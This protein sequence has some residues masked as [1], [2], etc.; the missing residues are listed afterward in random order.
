M[1]NRFFHP[2][3]VVSAVS[4][5]NALLTIIIALILHQQA[6]QWHAM[7]LDG[8]AGAILLV[9]GV[10]WVLAFITRRNVA[11]VRLIAVSHLAGAIATPLIV[12]DYWT[13][14]IFMLVLIPLEMAIADRVRNIPP[15]IIASLLGSA[16]M[17]AIDLLIPLNYPRESLTAFPW[18]ATTML[19]V[20]SLHLVALVFLLWY[21]RLR[22]RAPFPIRIDLGTQQSLIF[23]AISAFGIVIVTGVLIHQIHK[24]QLNQVGQN[25]QTLSQIN[26]ERVRNNLEQQI[27]VLNDLWRREQVLLDGLKSANASYPQDPEEVRQ[28]LVERE[29]L[30][31]TSPENSPFILNYRTNP[32]THVLNEFRGNNLLHTNLLLIDQHGGLVAAQGEKPDHFSFEHTD[33]WQ[34]TWNYGLGGTYL[35]H[36]AI[37]Q[38]TNLATILIAV[39]IIDPKTNQLMGVL[40]STYQL[41]SI[42]AMVTTAESSIDGEMFL[43]HASGITIASTQE[44]LIGHVPWP[45]LFISGTL[46]ARSESR[47]MYGQDYR[48]QESIIAYASLNRQSGEVVDP[49]GEL[50]WHIVVS[51]TRE[52]ALSQVIRSSKIAALVGLIVMALGIIVVNI[53][54]RIITR[55]IDALT[56]TAAIITEGNLDQR[57][58]PVGPVELV[59]LA[60]AFNTQTDRLRSLINN[61]QDQVAERTLQLEQRVRQLQDL[62]TRLQGELELARDIQQSLLPPRISTLRHLHIVCAMQPARSI[63]GD[64][65]S[66][67]ILD[68]DRL[69]VAVGDVSGKGVSAALLMATSLSLFD[70]FISQ[71]LSPS[72]VMTQLD[73]AL[74]PYTRPRRQNCAMCY[75]EFNGASLSVVNAGCIPPY[76]R[77]SD[78]HVESPEIGGFALGQ[79]I[80][81]RLSYTEIHLPLHHNDLVILTSDGVVEATSGTGELL[82]FERLEAIIAEGPPANAEGMLTHIHNA[83]NAFVGNNEQ[84]DD[85]TIVVIQVQASY[86][87]VEVTP[88]PTH[89]QG[90]V[91]PVPASPGAG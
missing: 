21:L 62:N 84:H 8:I 13:I 30:W 86:E 40:A 12:T 31:R 89:S 49:V 35:G 14:G 69:A 4:G 65:Y 27:V 74:L 70:T 22:P 61:L 25:F 18:F 6:G 72:E 3:W 9:H 66:Y 23:T 44:Q 7:A 51:D 17:V 80:E 87:V 81:K 24:S 78:G 88:S 46:S 60:E 43:F 54:A 56:T 85:M 1:K 64:F 32:Q 71:K 47:W 39:S 77:R 42:Q 76:L 90:V 67:R 5:M 11:A 63:G 41:R 58:R 73:H 79:G 28:L 48:D 10:A 33:W 20:F 53:A 19:A 59:T 45:R 16:A 82:G 2:F 57:A 50:N 52:N 68:D 55:P 38:E 15:I 75:A 91:P 29:R 34:A 26:I 83:I 36:L 37:D